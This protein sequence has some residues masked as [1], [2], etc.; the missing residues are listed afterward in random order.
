MQRNA[1]STSKVFFAVIVLSG[2]AVLAHAVLHPASANLVRFSSFLLV[3]GAAA[4]LKMKLP[5]LTGNMSVNLPFIL[6]AA[7]DLTSSEAIAIACFS[8]LM[9]CL[10]RGAQKF[11]IAQ[12]T[13]NLCNMA[14]AVGATRLALS[15]ASINSSLG[16][17]ALVLAGSA[18]AFFIANTGL[19]AIIIS[20]TEAKSAL[21]VWINIFELSFPYF[22]LSAAV[23]ALVLAAS[24][25]VG[26]QFPLLV[27]PIM[28]GVFKS[29]KRY[30]AS[31]FA[32]SPLPVAK[33]VGAS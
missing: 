7:A 27:L 15:V 33:A 28:F 3:A 4:R 13:F 8:T 6:V 20:L 9:Q 17:Y 10:P 12:V 11:N 14:L 5:G 25:Q 19:V 1:S 29:Y 22:V 32:V 24:T 16:S 31:E 18:V 30:F 26:W 2:C 21:K 23:A